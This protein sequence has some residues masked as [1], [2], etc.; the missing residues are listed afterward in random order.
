MQGPVLRVSLTLLLRAPANIGQAR[1]VMRQI[2]P[3]KTLLPPFDLI[4]VLSSLR[5][6]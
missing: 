3:I 5:V 4:L 2:A 6:L 1:N